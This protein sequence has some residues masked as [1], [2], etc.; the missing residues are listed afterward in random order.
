MSTKEDTLTL[1]SLTRPEVRA[2]I[3]GLHMVV[4]ALRAYRTQEEWA[5]HLDLKAQELEQ[6]LFNRDERENEDGR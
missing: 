3:Q 2:R 6:W 5:L 4:R 1:P